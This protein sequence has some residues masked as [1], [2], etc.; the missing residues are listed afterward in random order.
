M[1]NHLLVY[2]A[3]QCSFIRIKKPPRQPKCNVCGPNASIQSMEASAKACSIARGPTC[4]VGTS[5]VENG[6]KDVDECSAMDYDKVRLS[7]E[8]HILLD[9]R[10]PEQIDLC[11]LPGAVNIPMKELEQRIKEVENLS[12]GFKPVYCVCRRGIFSLAA[13][14]IIKSKL[15]SHPKIASVTNIKGGLDAWR[16]DVDPAFPKY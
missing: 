1:V 8:P 9:V 13:T 11:A 2:D 7:G 6:S 15:G 5:L 16:R 4:A 12:D 10:V 3:L 14:Q